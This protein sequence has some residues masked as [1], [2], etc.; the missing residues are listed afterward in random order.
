MT[1]EES[2]VQSYLLEEVDSDNYNP[3]CPVCNGCGESG[4]CGPINCEPSNINCHYPLT[5]TADL[6]LGYRGFH[7]FW[8]LLEEN[9]WFGKKEEF[10]E[11]YDEEL[12][13]RFKDE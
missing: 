11:I 8:D 4:C 3:Y 6:K 10:M 12:D 2:L 13:K 7:R 1:E 5:Y 9:N